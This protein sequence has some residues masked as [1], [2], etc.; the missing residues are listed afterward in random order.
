MANS[1]EDEICRM[2]KNTTCF[3]YARQT[4]AEA[5]IASLCSAE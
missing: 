4:C 3:S 2:I 1:F 5:P